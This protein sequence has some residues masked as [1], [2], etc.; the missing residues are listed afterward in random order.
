TPV[1]RRTRRVR[2]ATAA[3]RVSG[4]CRGRAVSESPTHT[5]S[6]PAASTRSAM[7]S[8]EAVSGRPDMTASRVGSSTPNSTA[9]PTPPSLLYHRADHV[10]AA[11]RRRVQSQAAPVDPAPWSPQKVLAGTRRRNC[12]AS[13]AP[14]FSTGALLTALAGGT[15]P[16][17]RPDRRE[18]DHRA[19]PRRALKEVRAHRERI[20]LSLKLPHG[21]ELEPT[22][23]HG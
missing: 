4:S 19:R 10:A 13:M 16:R 22:L 12:I 15:V 1:P 3:S 23:A 7:A 18:G 9:I 11:G 2:A 21:G 14:A 20:A 17:A 5:E 6:K 8:I